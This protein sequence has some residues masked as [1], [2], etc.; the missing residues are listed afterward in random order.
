MTQQLA[1]MVSSIK[2]MNT[3][4]TSSVPAIDQDTVFDINSNINKYNVLSLLRRIEAS[5]HFTGELLGKTLSPVNEQVRVC[6][7]PSLSF[8]AN[9]I[10]S[11]KVKD[12]A[13]QIAINEIG[14]LGVNS[15]LPLHLIE[16]IFQ[17]KHQYGDSTWCDFVNALQHRILTLFYRSWMNAQSV[18]SLENEY[19]DKFSNYLSSLVGFSG[20]DHHSPDNHVD[21]FSKL[22]FIGL[23]LQRN[24]SADNFESLLS[25][26]FQVQ[27]KIEENVGKWYKIPVHE[28]TCLNKSLKYNL[29]NGLL[30]GKKMYDVQTKFRI[31]I[32]PLN[33]EQFE[34]FFKGGRNSKKIIE[35]VELYIGRELDWDVQLILAE[36]SVPRLNSNSRNRLGLTTW[37]N[38]VNRDVDDVIIKYQ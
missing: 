37:L 35:W 6:Q 38:R 17:R 36:K 23:Y 8:C 18:L 34:S 26:Y 24:Q 25:E 3:I 30:L 9:N 10:D 14:L 4:D 16:F 22:Y 28:Q 15:P 31:K 21:Y 32:G 1:K 27:I 5:E 11:I 19:T 33:L 20:I 2:A 7:Y 12:H 29:G 13:I